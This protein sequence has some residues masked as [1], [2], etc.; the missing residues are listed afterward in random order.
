MGDTR[1]VRIEQGMLESRRPRHAGSNARLGDH[2]L[3]IQLSLVRLTSEDGV[4]GFGVSRASREVLAGLVGARIGE[5]F[6]P[7]RGA[8]EGW[9]ACEYPLWDLVGNRAGRPVYALAAE[10]NGRAVPTTLRVPCY[11]TSL[12]FD[13]LQV[14]DEGEAAALIAAEAR[15][16]FERGHRAF[17]I[18]V[19]RGAR[20]LPLEA[21]NQ[22]DIAV[23]RAV[24]E[25]VGPESPILLDANN[26][27]NLNIAKRVL[28]ETADCGVRWLEEAFHEDAILY[29]DLQEWLAAEGLP[30]W[31]ADGEG[32]ASP[33]LLDWA[34][35]GLIDVVQYDIFSYGFTPWLAT[36]R[37][38]DGWGRRSAPHHY[39][40]HYGNFVAG[41]LAAAIQGFSCIEWDEASCP[42]LDSSAYRVDEGWVT[43]P[44]VPGFG[45]GLDEGL[46]R[47]AVEARGVTLQL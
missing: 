12:Y 31:I 2:G 47:A 18:K 32:D 38:L 42:G 30:I 28:R 17:K 21:G 1:I 20:H 16:G 24:R 9:L 27:Y 26:G 40:R 22:R 39:G 11:D 23:I 6:D 29:R 36:G 15:E 41:H 43:I 34:R 46:F 3:T 25:A 33:R 10:V 19:G 8:A 35:D 13:D 4:T 7:A 45:L 14:A 44:D 5:A 37:Q